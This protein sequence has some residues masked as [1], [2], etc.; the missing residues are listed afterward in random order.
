MTTNTLKAYD[1][2]LMRNNTSDF[3]EK[4]KEEKVEEKSKDDIRLIEIVKTAKKQK[5]RVGLR[6]Y[7]EKEAS[8]FM[9]RR[10]NYSLEASRSDLKRSSVETT[11]VGSTALESSSRG[12]GKRRS[13][14]GSSYHIISGV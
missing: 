5:R 2:K 12:V 10:L 8:S 1:Y 9:I 3:K 14:R 7:E 4:L 13:A 6:M 11:R